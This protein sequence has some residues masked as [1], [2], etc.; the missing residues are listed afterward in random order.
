MI[1][2]LDTIHH[3]DV[4]EALRTWP[5]AFIDAVVTDPPYG[6]EFMGKSW[7]GKNIGKSPI[8]F[9]EWTRS[10][11]VEAFRVMKPGAHLVSFASTRTYHRMASGVED[12]GF[13]IRDQ[14]GW[15]F[16]SGFPKSKNLKDDWKGWGTALK[17]GWEPIVLARKPLEGIVEENVR[18]WGTGAL[19]IDGCRVPVDPRIDDMLRV[20]E[21]GKRDSKTWEEGSGFKNE[22]NHFTGVPESGRWPANLIH[23]GSDEVESLFPESKTARIEKPSNC[24]VGGATNFDNMRGN[25]PARGYEGTG[26]ASRFFYCAKASRADREE[27]LNGMPTKPLNW[28]SGEQS[29]GTFQ[30]PNTE[31]SV[32]NHHP[33]VKPTDLMRW[34]CRLVTPPGGL[35]LDP[36]FGSGSTGKAAIREGFHWLGIEKELEYI[37]IAER[38]IAGEVAQRK[39]F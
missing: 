13:E 39:M 30:S 15:L 32:Q 3:E 35:L 14:I 29:P 36:F 7:D 23:D 22:K 8:Q 10:W 20:V 2:Q 9:Q 24:S 33:T 17:P 25:R 37:K 4:L 21:R 5:D 16:G 27:H 26:S 38:R 31:R 28:S 6:I 19:N 18:K 34:L 1:P 11:A 12:A